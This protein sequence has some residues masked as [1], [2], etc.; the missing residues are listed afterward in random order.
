MVC[1]S[2]RMSDIP[3]FP[4]DLFWGERSMLSVANL[5]REDA[6]SFFKVVPQAGIVTHTH[7]YS[8]SLARTNEAIAAHRSRALQGAAVPV[9]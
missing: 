6:R 5:T 2:I 1:G 8:L 7:T 3:A 9:P 4:Y